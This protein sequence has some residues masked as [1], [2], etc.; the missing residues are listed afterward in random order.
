M[1]LI[2]RSRTKRIRKLARD[3]E[4]AKYKVGETLRKIRLSNNM[5]QTFVAN[6]NGLSSG[7][8]SLIESNNISASIRTLSKLIGFYGLKMSCLFDDRCG[9]KKFDVDKKGDRKIVEKFKSRDGVG[10]GYA[11]ESLA[12]EMKDKRMQPFVF[13]LSEDM[14]VE[15]SFSHDGESFVYVI[16]GALELFVEDRMLELTEGDSVYL[17]ASMEHRFRTKSGFGATVLMCCQKNY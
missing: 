11:C 14:M 2:Q 4:Y 12:F 7:M 10:T 8:I 5:T 13:T 9:T 15:K 17:D 1:T 3:N 16:R 6:E